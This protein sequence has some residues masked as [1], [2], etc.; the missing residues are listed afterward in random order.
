MSKDT[1]I[2]HS[3]FSQIDSLTGAYTRAAL[4]QFLKFENNSQ[5]WEN[6]TFSLCFI[7]LDYFKSINDAYGHQR[8]D[9]VLKEFVKRIEVIIR[10]SDYLFRYG[11]DEFILALAGVNKKQA[12]QLANRILTSFNEKPVEG[13]PPIKLTLS[14]GIAD[15]PVDGIV[16]GSILEIA[17]KRVYQAKELGRNR[18]VFL[19]DISKS[20]ID[21]RE[22]P[23]ILER[24]AQRT[25]FLGFLEN[26]EGHESA[27]FEIRGSRGS[28][29]SRFLNLCKEMATI[30]D[31]AIISINGNKQ[32]QYSPYGTLSDSR[33][34]CDFPFASGTKAVKE[35]LKK[36]IHEQQYKGIILAIDDIELID[37]SSISFL[38]KLL[39]EENPPGILLVYTSVADNSPGGIIKDPAYHQQVD[40]NTLSVESLAIWIRFVFHEEASEDFIN[41]FHEQTEGLPC[42]IAR[43]VKYL[44]EKIVSDKQHISD[45]NFYSNVDLK[46]EIREQVLQIPNNLPYMYTPFTGRNKEIYQIEKLLIEERMITLLGPGGIGKTRIS[47]EVGRQMFAYFEDG[48]F[49]ISLESIKDPALIADTISHSLNLPDLN[50]ANLLENLC[51]FLNKKKLLLI[52]DNFEHIIDGAPVLKRI[53]DDAPGVKILSSSREML[54]LS[55]ETIFRIPP[56]TLPQLDPLPSLEELMQVETVSLF[57]TR[58][59]N[60]QP[61]FLLTEENA[62]YIAIICHKL[63]GLPLAIELAAAQMRMFPPES[64]LKLLED[65]FSIL[66]GGPKDLPDRQQAL[67]NTIDWSY[68][69]LNHEE[70]KL[71]MQ[72]SVFFG[73]FGFEAISSVCDSPENMGVLEI[74]TSLYDKSLLNQTKSFDGSIRFQMLEILCQY[75][76]D[77][78]SG[79]GINK[80]LQDRHLKYYLDL[81]E[82]KE[83]TINGPKQGFWLSQLEDEYGNLRKALSYAIEINNGDCAIRIAAAVW[84]FFQLH[85]HHYEGRIWLEKAISLAPDVNQKVKAYEGAGW[86]A[87]VQGDMKI[88]EKNFKRGVQLGET[89]NENFYTGLNKHGIGAIA[90]MD[91]RYE[92][93]RK[94]FNESMP[95]FEKA[96]SKLNIAWTKS[97]LGVIDL[98]QGL[99]EQAI[100]LLDMAQ[101]IFEDK[102]HLWPLADMFTYKGHAY[103]QMKQF[104]PAGEYYE[105]AMSVYQ[106]LGDPASIARVGA[107]LAVV[108]METGEYEAALKKLKL[109]FTR[110]VELKDDFGIL[111]GMEQLSLAMMETEF[112]EDSARV[113]GSLREQRKIKGMKQHPG[114]TDTLK[115]KEVKFLEKIDPEKLERLF[116]EGISLSYVEAIDLCCRDCIKS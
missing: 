48:I 3:E 42:L 112:I 75:A 27:S 57:L 106:E 63:D 20:I 66:S 50:H 70:Q 22:F 87:Y 109:Y 18:S 43:G 103:L 16:P 41:W 99:F 91:G 35:N 71:F 94:A 83:D 61:D 40:L 39:S 52:M 76:W 33:W 5:S 113:F 115:E 4:D 47:I 32:V 111:W 49:F 116:T 9:E 79:D 97:H 78:H 68:D 11:G 74:L 17:D 55:C 31:F 80:D 45:Y 77:R 72:A 69:L 64:I 98:E 36:W 46:Q 13:I 114:F 73:G 44:I 19:D 26:N 2:S 14:I 21:D 82:A 25:S 24:E 59:Q 10:D 38:K 67:R 51:N 65:R 6:T 30:Q 86:L 107:Y 58:A 105:K 1:N 102:K 101:Q 7:D 92:D 84:K 54:H 28:G 23:R 95:Y 85:N 108:E 88:A 96:N 53:L 104:K 34:P 29:R 12:A 37:S 110:S 93:A 89:L 60:Q 100:D 81:I 8:G 56:L 90:R 15:S 62:L